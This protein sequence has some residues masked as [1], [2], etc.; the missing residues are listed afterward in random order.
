MSIIQK[1]WLVKQLELAQ[2]YDH[3]ITYAHIPFHKFATRKQEE[4][5]YD[6]ELYQ[7]L[8]DGRVS[9]HLTGHHHVFYPGQNRDMSFVSVGCIGSG[10]RKLWGSD[11]RQKQSFVLLE[12]DK[13]INVRSID[14][15]TMKEFD[16]SSLPEALDFGDE[17]L[18]KF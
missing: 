9:I 12:I 1:K 10:P 5:I 4:I 6:P 13:E 11:I 16:T 18:Y 2:A 14:A 3:R 8:I 7:I 15:T 17:V